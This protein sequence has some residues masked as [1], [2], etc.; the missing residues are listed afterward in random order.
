MGIEPALLSSRATGKAMSIV[1]YSSSIVEDSDA[2]VCWGSRLLQIREDPFQAG[3]LNL[4]SCLSTC[5]KVL[6]G[7]WMLKVPAN[8]AI[9]VRPLLLLAALLLGKLA[10]T[11]GVDL[12]SEGAGLG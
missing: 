1:Y 6:H 3:V 7:L 9:H 10:V 2:S 12:S 11:L 5:P 8:P 4:V